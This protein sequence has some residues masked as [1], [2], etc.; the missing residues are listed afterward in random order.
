LVS[1]CSIKLIDLLLKL[2]NIAPARDG[3]RASGGRGRGNVNRSRLTNK[4]LEGG[5]GGTGAGVKHIDLALKKSCS[6][7][8]D[9]RITPVVHEVRAA[10]KRLRF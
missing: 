3:R 5:L 9:L 2:E 10:Q 8:A 4:R 7:T 6:H 1:F